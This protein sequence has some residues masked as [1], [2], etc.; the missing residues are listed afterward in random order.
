MVAF[1]SP[2]DAVRFAAS[3]QEDLMLADWPEDILAH[4]DGKEVKDEKTN[5]LIFRGLRVRMVKKIES[6][7]I[8]IFSGNS[9][10]KTT[11]PARSRYWSNGLFRSNGQ[12][13]CPHLS[14]REWRTS[15]L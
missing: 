7:Q 6:T 4:Q 11:M 13:N 5:S 10:W 12:Q 2:L 15:T 3:V 1:N 14:S 8:L 9:H